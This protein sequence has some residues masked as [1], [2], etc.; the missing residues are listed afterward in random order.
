VADFAE[1]TERDIFQPLS[2]T[3]QM[4]VNLDRRLSHD[5]MCFVTPADQDKVISAGQPSM[6]I[7]VVECQSQ[8]GG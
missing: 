2:T 4:F 6:T 3:V 1:F 8:Q 5:R 7:V